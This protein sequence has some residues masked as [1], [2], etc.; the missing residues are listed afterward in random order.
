MLSASIIIPTFNR[1]LELKNCIQSILRQ[2]I[3]PNELIIMDDGYTSELPLEVEC[4]KAGIRYVYHKKEQRG[5]TRS[6]NIGVS[7][8]Q[9][10]IIFFFDDD[11]VL[12]PSY[13]E[14]ILKIYRDDSSGAVGGVGGVIT[15]F[16]HLGFIGYIRQ[17]VEGFFMISGFKEGRVLPSGFCVNFAESG[18]PVKSI[19]PVDFLPGCAMSFRK[20]IFQEFSFDTKRYLNYGYGE[21]KDFTFRVSRRYALIINPGAKLEHLQSPHMRSDK[22]QRVKNFVLDRY[23]FFQNYIRKSWSDWIFFGYAL[24]GYTLLRTIAFICLPTKNGYARL[25]GICDAMQDIFAGRVV[26]K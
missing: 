22:R 2:T 7:M 12:S 18:F 6:R 25:R 1:P 26:V 24:F 17:F 20:T 10:D 5:L 19:S 15:N 16:S 3:K 8:A 13:L 14:E 23:L 9:S 11:V 21:D 4:K